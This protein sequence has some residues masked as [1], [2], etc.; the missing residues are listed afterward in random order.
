MTDQE[1]DRQDGQ[2]GGV[3]GRVA[4]GP[5]VVTGAGGTIGT[6]LAVTFGSLGLRLVLSDYD[7]GGVAVTGAQAMA[8]G[9]PEVRIV[10]G[11]AADPE[12][13]TTLVDACADWGGPA[14]A[15][16]NA[17][18]FVA[19]LVWEQP[20]DVWRRQV[21]VD[22][23]G[24]VH[25]VRAMVPAMLERGSGH[26]V[27]VSS[28]AGLVATPGMGAYVSAKHAVVGMMESLHH[29][30]VRLDAPV[31][32]SVVCP[33]LVLSNLSDNSLQ[34]LDVDPEDHELAG[35]AAEVDAT[36]R[37]G[38]DA[39]APAQTVADAVLSAVR[40]GSFWVLPQPEV[41]LGA[42]DRYRRLAEGGPPV[43]LL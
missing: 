29:E 9:A 26:V 1:P 5:V 4:D 39:G 12:V 13:A 31:R 23:W 16:F 14:V 41:A 25:G 43:D 22:Y 15:V 24:P 3:L 19:G 40:D 20:I 7:E 32:A 35:V 34:A 42:L 36:I 37:A 33:G 8:A 28:G 6:A 21:E 30:L 11:D 17:G 18:I 10:V 27:A 2:D 38:V